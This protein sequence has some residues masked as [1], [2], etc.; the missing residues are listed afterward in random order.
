[1]RQ[2]TPLTDARIRNAK[3][4]EKAYRLF[5]GKGL[6]LEVKPTGARYWRLK[7]RVG[8]KEKLLAL[9]VYPEVSLAEARRLTEDARKLVTAGRDPVTERRAAK[10]VATAKNATTFKDVAE[11]WIESRH[12]NWA[13]SYEAKISEVLQTNLYPRI[14][15]LPIAEITAPLLL[16]ALKP[17]EARG[18][19]ELLGR[20]R[21]WCS[22][23]MRYAIATGRREDDPAAA[24]KGAFKTR[25]ATNYPALRRDELG[26]FQRA[27]TDYHGR[28]ESRLAVQLL[29]LTFVRPGELRAA[30][31]SEFDLDGRE[32]RIPAERMKRRAE[33]L[34]P[35]SRQAV[36]ALR[37]L[38]ELTGFSLYL[39]PGSG[40][41][42]PYISENT[43]NKTIA[44][45]GY[46][47]RLV[48]HG[49]RATASTILNE[50][51]KFPADA[52]ERQLAHVE[53]NKIR[54]AYHRAEYLAERRHMM[55]WW[56]DFLDATVRGADVVPLAGRG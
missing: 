34:V 9:G 6:Y 4:R 49:F 42:T 16:A 47:G 25:T 45:L 40:K 52:I 28:P 51:G 35:L 7:Y 18:A 20:A 8:G 17:I 11:E 31:W 5:D 32:W 21:R 30:K 54:G 27:L 41:R 22:E 3:A 38:H 37:E 23:I 44:L 43:V 48:A 53:R 50:S 10:V 24:L 36:A 39:F 2:A 26:A 55:Q 15:A 14:G 56:A 33:H 13:P 19:L 1:M 29:L 12:E 46:K